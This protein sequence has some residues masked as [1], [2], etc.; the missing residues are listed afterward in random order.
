MIKIDLV[1]PYVD[2]SDPEWQKL[3]NQYNP[4]EEQNEQ[5]NALSRFRG[6][7]DFFKYFFRCLDKN[8]PW[9]GQVHL[10]VQSVSQIPDWIDT[11]KVHIVLHKDFIPQEYLPT[12]NSTCIE[13]FLHRIPGLSEYFIYTNDDVFVIKPLWQIDFFRAKKVKTSTHWAWDYHI[14]YGHHVV[15]GYSL[16]FNK[17]KESIIQ[18]ARVPCLAH[19]MRPYIKSQM[20]ICFQKYEPTILNSISPFRAEY[21]LNIYIFDY[22][23]IKNRM[24]YPQDSIK[25]LM[26]ASVT[27]R[28][29]WEKI[30]SNNGRFLIINEINML[31]IQDNRDD[32]NIY[33]DPLLNSYFSTCYPTKSKYE[34]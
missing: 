10:L 30:F 15:N 1:V 33:E 4:S 28:D 18:E 19:I 6:Q 23:A 12:F 24:S 7:G 20:A 9:L 21:N 5:I 8:L 14:L 22:Y 2:S 25:N 27:N 34:K 29:K 26:V 31:C 32:I 16:I 11:T 17:S 13:M 3:Y